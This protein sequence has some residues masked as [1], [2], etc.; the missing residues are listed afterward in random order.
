MKIVYF[1]EFMQQWRL[2]FKV[3][4]QQWKL[5]LNHKI[6]KARLKALIPSQ[7]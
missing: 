2:H 4:M 6:R 5:Q 7:E 3:Y 1:K